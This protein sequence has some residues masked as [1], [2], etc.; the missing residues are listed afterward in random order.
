MER[1]R[2]RG[3][4][5]SDVMG[6]LFHILNEYQLCF[7]AWAYNVQRKLVCWPLR[8]GS[9]ARL[10]ELWLAKSLKHV[11]GTP[12]ND[13]KKFPMESFKKP[14]LGGVGGGVGDIPWHGNDALKGFRCLRDNR[15]V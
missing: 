4:W 2:I 6:T 14:A 9:G 10:Q 8:S 15:V 12:K 1:W 13:N 11:G 5:S 7:R 3:F